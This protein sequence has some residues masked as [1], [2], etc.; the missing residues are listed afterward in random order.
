MPQ[1]NISILS[2]HS[3]RRQSS[4][5]SDFSGPSVSKT[6]AKL[7]AEI[8]KLQAI[9]NFTNAELEESL[10]Q[11]RQEMF[12]LLEEEEAKYIKAQKNLQS[13]RE[14]VRAKEEYI[15]Y[16]QRRNEHKDQELKYVEE[17]GMD[18][19]RRLDLMSAEYEGKKMKAGVLESEVT[20]LLDT[21]KDLLAE[22]EKV[23]ASSLALEKNL[24]DDAS[25]RMNR[26]HAMLDAEMEF[27][28]KSANLR[29]M[30]N[31]TKLTD[32]IIKQKEGIQRIVDT[33]SQEVYNGTDK[34]RP[35]QQ[36]LLLS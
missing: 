33:L 8:S 26:L 9:K 24:Q 16:V 2:E 22:Q 14:E 7:N 15:S 32:A 29:A 4:V 13:V 31:G 6:I 5:A 35:P 30:G 10:L 1:H 12:L 19:Q 36:L 17:E 34:T 27:K 21:F 25:K 11:R 18:L 20:A 28:N 23:A 3:I